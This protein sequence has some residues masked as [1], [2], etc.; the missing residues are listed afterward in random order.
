[1]PT[2]CVTCLA[3][4]EAIDVEQLVSAPD[5]DPIVCPG[6][7]GRATDLVGVGASPGHAAA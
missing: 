5:D 6:C 7:D 4:G 2:L 1:V 3:C